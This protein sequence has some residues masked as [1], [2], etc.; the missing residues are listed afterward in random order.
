MQ[1]PEHRLRRRVGDQ[2]A[3]RSQNRA[4][5]QLVH[6]QA[7]EQVRQH[8]RQLQRH[9]NEK[10][11]LAVGVEGVQLVQSDVQLV[12]RF[13]G[14]RFFQLVQGDGFPAAPVAEALQRRAQNVTA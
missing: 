9:Q 4:E 2:R 7:D 13:G 6:R 10:L 8:Q 12:Q 11:Q 5:N 3:E 14:G 1:G